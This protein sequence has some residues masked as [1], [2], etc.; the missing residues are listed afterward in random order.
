MKIPTEDAPLD[1]KISWCI[2]RIVKI[3]KSICKPSQPWYTSFG[4]W[5]AIVLTL[6]VLLIIYVFY[7]STLGYTTLY[8]PS[9]M[10]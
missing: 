6:L 2:E 10:K 7:L 9:W 1:Y 5:F 8:L 4:V 3:E